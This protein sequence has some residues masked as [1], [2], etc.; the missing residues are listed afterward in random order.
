MD[1]H[2]DYRHSSSLLLQKSNNTRL[3]WIWFFC[4]SKSVHVAYDVTSSSILIHPKVPRIWGKENH[5]MSISPGGTDSLDHKAKKTVKLE[6]G[7]NL[8]TRGS[9]NP[10]GKPSP[11]SCGL[12]VIQVI[13]HLPFQQKFTSAQTRGRARDRLK[14]MVCVTTFLRETAGVSCHAIVLQIWLRP[15]SVLAL[16]A[17]SSRPQPLIPN[18]PLQLLAS[19]LSI[20]QQ[21]L[22]IFTVTCSD[23]FKTSKLPTTPVLIAL[24][25]TSSNFSTT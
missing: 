8:T 9:V 7:V 16:R 19:N 25:Q 20:L 13:D 22:M 5:I 14:V 17:Q 15:S 11:D 24:S 12:E 23:E 2:S 6:T 4:H 1:E 21:T 18:H 10:A 3:Q